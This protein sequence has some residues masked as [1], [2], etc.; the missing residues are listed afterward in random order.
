MNKE[1]KALQANNTWELVSL[2]AS[3]KSISCTCVYKVKY[4]A[5]WSLERYK[6]FYTEGRDRLNRD[7]V[8][9]G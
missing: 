1:F 2:S 9:C 3:K 6:G 7:L 4:K 8:F 5:D